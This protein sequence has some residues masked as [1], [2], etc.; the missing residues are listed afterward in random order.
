[1]T[2]LALILAALTIPAACGPTPDDGVATSGSTGD[3][4][5][6]SSSSGGDG[7]VCGEV[8]ASCDPDLSDCGPGL[9]CVELPDAP[10]V[11]VCAS[12]CSTGTGCPIGWCD[13]TPDGRSGICRD[14]DGLPTGLC[15]GTPSCA[16]DPCEATCANGLSCVAGS[17]ALA[18]DAAAGCEGT[19]ACIAGVCFDGDGLADP[20]N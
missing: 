2:R 10:G 4:P 3:A 17:C 11:H 18:C 14:A 6:D 8:G 13:P 12:R 20:C 5:A 19:Q 15:F 9:D 7:Y 16:G 1:M